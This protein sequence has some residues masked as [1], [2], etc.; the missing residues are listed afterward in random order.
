MTLT[1]GGAY[2]KDLQGNE[3]IGGTIGFEG[4]TFTA[5]CKYNENE[6]GCSVDCSVDIKY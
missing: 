2:S 6:E 1:I 5:G 3:T 4:D